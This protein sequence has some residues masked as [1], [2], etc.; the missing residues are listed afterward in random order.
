[1][2]INLTTDLLRSFD[3]IIDTGSMVK[4]SERVF[5]TQS[6]LSLQ[7]KRLFDMLQVPIL[8]RQQG[9]LC[10]TPAGDKLLAHAREILERND[11]AVESLL[12]RGLVGP[13]RVGMVQD[14]ADEIL[15]RVLARFS[16]INVEVDLQI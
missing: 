7:M 11:H 6:A 5:L 16:Q 8:H 3:A 9:A 1:M 4:A 12:G 15:Q 13:V 14:F 10:L 2:R